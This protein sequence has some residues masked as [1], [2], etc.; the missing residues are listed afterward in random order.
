MPKYYVLTP[1]KRV[2]GPS[3]AQHSISWWFPAGAIPAARLSGS[4]TLP[5][6]W[7]CRC[8]CLPCHQPGGERDLLINLTNPWIQ[9]I[10]LILSQRDLLQDNLAAPWQL[11]TPQTTWIQEDKQGKFSGC[12]SCSF[13]QVSYYCCQY[14]QYFPEN[15]KW[16]KNSPK[17]P[18]LGIIFPAVMS[19]VCF[20][21]EFLHTLTLGTRQNTAP[22]YGNVNPV[23]FRGNS[24]SPPEWEI[25]QEPQKL[26]I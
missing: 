26:W 18:L 6:P 7:P 3:A 8:P 14:S 2:W 15:A 10:L 22:V 23:G 11:R 17:I 20:Q 5:W 12:S 4:V 24:P 19:P 9:T 21:I 16:S 25:T 1:K 13:T